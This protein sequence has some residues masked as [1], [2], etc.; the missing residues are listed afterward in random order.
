MSAA[1][2][3]L[4]TQR[5]NGAKSQRMDDAVWTRRV[6]WHFQRSARKFSYRKR[7][8]KKNERVI[9]SETMLV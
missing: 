1:A 7:G 3:L 8:G 4:S 2:E 6:A 9:R 5:G